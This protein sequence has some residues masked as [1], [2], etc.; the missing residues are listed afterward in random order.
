MWA[1][2]VGKQLGHPTRSVAGW[3]ISKL[4]TARNRVLEENA[5]QLSKIQPGDT[6]LELGHGP[7]LGLQAAAKLLTEPTGRLIGVDYSEYMHQMASERLKEL[8]ASG[9][10]TLH[11]CDVAAMPL[12]ESTVDKVFHCNCYY[13]WPD[14]KKGATEIHRVMK[15]GGLM[16]TT[17]RLF[18]VAT[19]AAKQVMPGENWQPEAYM[20]ALR[21]SGFSDVRM[22]DIQD[23]KLSFQAIYATAWK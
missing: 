7:G 17:L 13:F 8:V 5:V 16:V 10:V 1:E 4:L 12:A 20:A 21:D 22:E 14:L 18:H 6:V 3:L 23:K 19:M 15:P 11:H 2:K 9:K